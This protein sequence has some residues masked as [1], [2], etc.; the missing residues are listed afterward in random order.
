[1]LPPKLTS[2]I[3]DE[4]KLERQSARNYSRHRE[5][6]LEAIQEDAMTQS[7][8]ELRR[9]SERSRAEL[10]TTL[11]QLSAQI[12]VT[13]EDIRQKVS[14]QHVKSEVS[15][16][17]SN[18]TRGWADGLKRQAME[19]PLQA[20]AAGSA[21]AVPVLR[22]VRGFPLPLLMI[23]VG[24]ALTSKTVRDRASEA[25]APAMDKAREMMG[26]AAQRAQSL[27]SDVGNAVS[28][29]RDQ[30]TGMASHAQDAA[31][32]VAEEVRNQAAR[33][34]GAIS[35]KLKGGIDTAKETIARVRSTAK[36]TAAATKDAA[37][38]APAKAGQLIGDNAALIGGLGIAI[39]AIIAAALPETWAEAKIMGQASGTVR[40]AAGEA[41][42]SGVEVAKDVAMSA[43]DA[44]A[45]SVADADLGGHASRMAKNMTDTLKEAADD[46]VTSAFNPSRNPNT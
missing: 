20:I 28:S 38:A 6:I 15:D 2:V 34:G 12:T 21:I 17:I 39:G 40:Q 25:A 10:A 3:A 35:D 7:V 1:M 9:Q 24:L 11:D 32:G 36:D 19:N 22:L 14:P 44:A 45:K 37:V 18:K 30:G 4:R 29:V 26:D 46:V 13:A 42:Q 8:E 5:F 27:G 41:A 31:A 23:G 33:A 16:F 43:A